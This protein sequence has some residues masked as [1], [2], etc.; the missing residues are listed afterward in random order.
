MRLS[1]PE[2][3]VDL[4][5]LDDFKGILVNRNWIRGVHMVL[6]ACL[7]RRIFAYRPC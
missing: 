1:S 3:L 2:I 7:N 6:T 5:G 4:A